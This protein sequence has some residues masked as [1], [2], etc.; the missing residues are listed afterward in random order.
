M[1]KSNDFKNSTF[2]A[3][4]FFLLDDWIFLIY[5]HSLKNV[6]CQFQFFVQYKHF[7]LSLS[8]YMQFN[9]NLFST[10]QVLNTNRQVHN[11]P[12]DYRK[13]NDLCRHFWYLISWREN[14]CIVYTHL[15]LLYAPA[16]ILHSM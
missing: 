15:S 2:D 11:A 13:I 14:S 5:Y 7:M 10:N 9:G 8:L 16:I 4:S 6:S 12:C 3:M 1:T